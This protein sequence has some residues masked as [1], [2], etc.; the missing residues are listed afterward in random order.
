MTY[1]IL[2]CDLTSPTMFVRAC[3]TM[4]VKRAYPSESRRTCSFAVFIIFHCTTPSDRL[5]TNFNCNLTTDK[6]FQSLRFVFSSFVFAYR[7][8]VVRVLAPNAFRTFCSVFQVIVSWM[9]FNFCSFFFFSFFSSLLLYIYAVY[10][11][12]TSHTTEI[13]VAASFQQNTKCQY[14]LTELLFDGRQSY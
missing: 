11:S 8:Y 4:S 12:H 7:L 9:F 5:I 10:T 2:F 13:D 1:F 3:C 6:R 14:E